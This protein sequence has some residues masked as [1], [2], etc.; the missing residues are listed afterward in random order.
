MDQSILSSRE[1]LIY[2]ALRFS[3]KAHDGQSR[4]YNFDKYPEDF[5]NLSFQEQLINRA[6]RFSDQA[7]YH[8]YSGASTRQL[9]KYT[10]EPYI[11]HPISVADIVS[12]VEHTTEM[13]AAALLHDVVED[14]VVT[15]GDIHR[16]FGYEVGTLVDW[17]TD[18][19]RPSDGN[20]EVRKK[21]DQNHIAVAP[22]NAKTIK[23]A[24][25]IDNTK[26]IAT[27]DPKFWRV[28]REEKIRLLEVL[29]DGDKIL[30]NIAKKQIDDN[31]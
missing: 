22:A 16:E 29:K 13:V 23:L 26:T 25:L 8:T 10:N 27:L 31:P 5:E 9:R 18:V 20:R 4:K 3:E 28:Y 30:W 6:I 15:S 14:T 24:D 19:S 2:R 12:S 17:L 7:H 1:K 21:I 11:N